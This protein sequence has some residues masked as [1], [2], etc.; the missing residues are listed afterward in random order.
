LSAPKKT[1]PKLNFKKVA[2]NKLLTIEDLDQ[3]TRAAQKAIEFR[4][5]LLSER[6]GADRLS[7]LRQS[8]IGTLAVL[9]AMIEDGL[10][11]WVDG[12]EIDHAAL[13]SIINARRREAELIGLDPEPKDITPGLDQ[14]LSKKKP[15]E[16]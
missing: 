6:G 7:L 3:R 11:R 15:D 13:L 2:Q 14:Y 4:D 10:T 16:A 8:M 12:Q 1:T 5:R 9:N